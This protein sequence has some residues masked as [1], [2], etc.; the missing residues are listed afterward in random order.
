M[1][2]K[3]LAHVACFLLAQL[4]NSVQAIDILKNVLFL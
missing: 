1:P 3:A 2:I 4:K